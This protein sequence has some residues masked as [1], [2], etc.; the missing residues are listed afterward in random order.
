MEHTAEAGETRPAAGWQRVCL[1]LSGLALLAILLE[2]VL[3]LSA[4]TVLIS[5]HEYM[6]DFWFLLDAM[7]RVAQGQQSSVDFHSPIGPAFYGVYRVVEGWSPFTL[8]TMVR[9]DLLVALVVVLLCVLL[10]RG[11]A[12]IE[13]VALFALLGF[14]VAISGRELGAN[15]IQRSYSFLAPYNRW[16]WALMIPALAGLLLSGRR[17]A[18]WQAVLLGLVG[19]FLLFMKLSYFAVYLGLAIAALV[20]RDDAWPRRWSGVIPILLPALATVL[21]SLIAPAAV[22]GYFQDLQ[23]AAAINPL[24]FGKL[25]QSAPEAALFLGF[26]LFI[27]FLG[28]RL[29]R[30]VWRD[31]TCVV[32]AI[33][34]G[35]AILL[36]NHEIAD[37]PLYAAALILAYA[38]SRRPEAARAVP[39]APS[40]WSGAPALALT[41]LLCAPT[42]FGNLFSPVFQLIGERT[43]QV[44]RFTIFAGTPMEAFRLKDLE[45]S[46]MRDDSPVLAAGELQ[47]IDCYWPA[48]ENIKHVENGLLALRAIAPHPRSILS[49]DFG[50][51]FPA[52]LHVSSPRNAVSWFDYGRSF[53]AH[54]GPQPVELYRTSEIVMVPLFKGPNDKVV[55]LYAADLPHYYTKIAQTADWAIWR[56][57]PAMGTPAKDR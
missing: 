39:A 3:V 33:G 19:T 14:S 55:Q 32:L 13:T 37:V 54:T 38:L 16:G 30:R 18:A 5:S 6:N 17:L 48:C 56:H 12:T 50:N 40:T 28:G 35:S 4:H 41:L 22:H 24:R 23:G 29:H 45:L 10:L 25:F 44:Y 34:A 27:L 49:L 36:Q 31:F 15:V 52:L 42:L 20:L 8:L 51:P 9:A 21:F 1:A 43:G 2:T 26:G 46:L 7:W 11:H 57:R 47:N 53:D